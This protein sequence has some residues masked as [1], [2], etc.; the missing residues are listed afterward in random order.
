MIYVGDLHDDIIEESGVEGQSDDDENEEGPMI[1]GIEEESI[2]APPARDDSILTFT[3][4]EA[5]IFCV[6][7]HPTEN[8]AVTGGEDDKAYVWDVETGEVVHQVNDHHDSVISVEFSHDGVYVATADIAGEIQVFKTTSQ[9]KKVWSFSMGDMCWMKWHT[10]A[11]ILM[12]G[13]ES[14]EIYIWRIPSG[15]CKVLQG[16][17]EKCET[18]TLTADGK[19]LAAGYGDGTFKLWDIKSCATLIEMAPNETLGHTGTITSI[20]CDKENNMILTGSEDG[21]ATLI[22]PNGPVGSLNPDS[23]PIETVLLDSPDFDTKI[24][25]TGTLTS[26]ITI[27]D[28]GRQMPR[29][30]YMD[31]DV[32]QGV[33]K[34]VWARNSTILAGTLSGEL[35]A[36]DARTGEQKFA[37]LGHADNIHDLCYDRNRNM[38]L[39]ASE[40]GTAKLFRYDLPI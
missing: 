36:I 9:Y 16:N 34:M 3:K 37:L 24:A 31:K 22:G 29:A 38:I 11:Y 19:K 21:K 27:W 25:V 13:S 26:K 6:A 33:T 39:T 10:G 5:P 12:A 30:D 40:D 35:R 28:V 18:G 20:S 32:L 2:R 8:L 4:H 1:E 17:G 23:G 7:L 14:G 15:E